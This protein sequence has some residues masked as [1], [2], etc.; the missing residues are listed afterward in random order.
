MHHRKRGG[1]ILYY[2]EII[3]PGNINFITCEMFERHK[4]WVSHPKSVEVSKK[5]FE[6]LIQIHQKKNEANPEPNNH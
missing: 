4:V 1:I 6:Y 3:D 2:V 5:E